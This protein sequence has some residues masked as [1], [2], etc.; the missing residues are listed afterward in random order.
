M[1][2]VFQSQIF[3]NCFS[4]INHVLINNQL[5]THLRH[6]SMCNKLIPLMLI[7]LSKFFL[8]YLLIC[9]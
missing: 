9:D 5:S 7:I 8:S 2:L 6:I 4:V 3:Y 1:A